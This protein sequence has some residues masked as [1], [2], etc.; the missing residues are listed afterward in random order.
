MGDESKKRRRADNEDGQKKKCIEG[1]V[2]GKLEGGSELLACAER[3][4][5]VV[6]KGRWG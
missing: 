1:K 6:E 3:G 5:R 2:G 4:R